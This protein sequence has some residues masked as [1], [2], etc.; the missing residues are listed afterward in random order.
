MARIHKLWAFRIN[1]FGNTMFLD[2]TVVSKICS[3][4]KHQ[5]KLYQLLISDLS[6]YNNIL[7]KIRRHI[8]N[9]F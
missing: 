2:S 9:E 6:F 5:T 7:Q 8:L 1:S 4:K 3:V